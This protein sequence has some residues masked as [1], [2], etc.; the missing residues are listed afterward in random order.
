MFSHPTSSHATFPRPA[1][2][3]RHDQTPGAAKLYVTVTDADGLQRV[4]TL[5]NGRNHAF[6]RFE[7]E[8]AGGG[9]WALRLDVVGT[10]A[11]LDLVAARI[12]RVPSVLAVEVRPGVTLSAAG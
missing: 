3:P 6:T 12:D 8:E 2:L 10:P 1:A 11:Q 9:R 7:A 4:L 5:L